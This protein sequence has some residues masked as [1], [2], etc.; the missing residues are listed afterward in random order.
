MHSLI[1]FIVRMG[2]GLSFVL[3]SLIV[4]SLIR[5][6]LFS[7]LSAISSVTLALF[8]FIHIS[9]ITLETDGVNNQAMYWSARS[10]LTSILRPLRVEL[11]L[12][13]LRVA[14]YEVQRV[15]LPRKLLIFIGI[16]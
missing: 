13:L 9:I 2:L 6:I 5:S 8:L 12:E 4:Q 3:I 16:I 11:R 7:V 14:A 10:F 1:G 15:G